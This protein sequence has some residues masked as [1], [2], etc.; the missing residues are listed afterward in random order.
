MSSDK[1]GLSALISALTRNKNISRGSLSLLLASALP[2]ANSARTKGTV[3]AGQQGVKLLSGWTDERVHA[4]NFGR[5]T[6]G[7]AAPSSSATKT[8]H[9]QGLLSNAIGGAGTSSLLSG[10][11]S[12][13]LGFGGLISGIAGLLSGSSKPTVQPLTLFSLPDSIQQHSS[14]SG[15]GTRITTGAARPN[16][17]SSGVYS[18]PS[19][20][21]G[22]GASPR[23]PDSNSVAQAVKNALLTSNS[24]ADVISDL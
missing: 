6:S 15:V 10:G 23:V 24:L 4:I 19:P 16:L 22:S 2:A 20:K 11:L 12:S 5:P 3:D 9:W 7:A 21:T 13:F 17:G 8:D 14:I 18:T 1:N